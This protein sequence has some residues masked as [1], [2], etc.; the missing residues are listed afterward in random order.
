MNDVYEKLL[1]CFNSFEKKISFKPEKGYDYKVVYVADD[2]S[3][4]EMVTEVDENS[5]AF[6]TGHFSDYVVTK[7]KEEPKPTEPTVPETTVPVTTKPSN[8][9]VPNTGDNSGVTGMMLLMLA[10]GTMAAALWLSLRKRSTV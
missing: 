2:G 4:T 1:K 10:S 3:I 9:A 8:P 5:L 7:E 6:W